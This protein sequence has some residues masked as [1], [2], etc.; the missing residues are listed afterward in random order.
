MKKYTVIPL[1]LAI[2]II[3]ASGVAIAREFTEQDIARMIADAP[4]PETYPQASALVLLS[5]KHVRCD[6]KGAVVAD[7]YLVVKILQDRG[8]FKYADLKRRYD[9]ESDSIVV[10]KAVTHL[11]DG[12]IQEVQQKAINDI[13]P[14]ELA[15]AAVY[16]NIMQKVVSFPGIAP[17]VTIELKLRKFSK[18]PEE[19]EEHFVWNTELFQGDEP[20]S[21]KEVSVTTPVEMPVTYEVQNAEITHEL[22][23]ADGFVTHTWSKSDATQIMPEPNMPSYSKIAPRLIY[24][25]ADSWE[26]IGSW[27]ADK[28]YQHVKTDKE[29][30]AKAKELTEGLS[31]KDDKIK[32]ICLFVINDIRDVGEWSLPLGSA[33]YEPHDADV[34][35]K[36]KYGDW[37]DK[38]VLLVSLLEAAGIE[39]RPVFAH[40]DSPTLA[41]AHPSL[42]QFNALFVYVPDY[43]GQPL[44]VNP[45]A[46][47]CYFGYFPFG[48][49][50]KGLAVSEEETQI[51][52]IVETSAEYNLSLSTMNL[53][54]KPNG[55]LEG[56]VA[57][58][59]NG[60]FDWRTR[61]RLKQ[62]TPKKVE[63]FFQAAANEIS[64]GTL[65][66]EYKL[67][68][69]A[70]L[71]EPVKISQ[72]F[73]AP[74]LGVVE[75]DMMIF[76]PP[77]VPF[78]F[79]ALPVELGQPMRFNDFTLDSK[80]SVKTEGIIQMPEGFT[81]VYV[82]E[83]IT[84][85][86]QFGSW[87]SAYTLSENG[88]EIHYT[89]ETVITDKEIAISEFAEFKQTFD[90]FNRP[91]NSLILLERK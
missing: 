5:R 39:S 60:Y 24:T 6:S 75:G 82:P 84:L 87:S 49:A 79:A 55:N 62:S 91:Q 16:A 48:Q 40:R 36:N 1:F 18:A 85:Q 52:D 64:E 70:D 17:G 41:E 4:G 59:L 22:T 13:S 68:D 32:Q 89:T 14:S 21:Y 57:C 46:D 31:S 38:A 56:T 12:T 53:Q 7:E 37:R 15:N 65:N 50:A 61:S 42:K 69:L 28:F 88:D 90:D 80:M 44:W 58:R 26:H 63:Q 78:Y 76:Y 8:K 19:G 47:H 34:A 20:I 86:N 27:F 9:K 72:S 43:Q 11:Q 73:T 83:P 66:V 29:I 81:A 71:V 77:E 23:E 54:L 33:G 2:F 51:V 35:L 30:K 10:L 25:T 67:S 45:F 74:E 3:A